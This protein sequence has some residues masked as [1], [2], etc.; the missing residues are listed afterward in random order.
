MKFWNDLR[1]RTKIFVLVA[2]G[3]LGLVVTGTLGLYNMDIMKNRLEGAEKDMQEVATLAELKNNFLQ[4]RLDLVYMLSL[5]DSARIAD[6]KQDF[7]QRAAT[8]KEQLAKFR[9]G[10]LSDKEKTLT[11][12]FDDGFSAYL[13][14][15]SKLGEMAKNAAA[16]GDAQARAAATDFA[17]STVAPLYD[18][19]AQAVTTIATDNV[20]DGETTFARSM[21]RFRRAST[22]MTVI[23]VGICLFAVAAGLAIA[24]SISRPLNRVLEVL[25]RVAAGDLTARADAASRDEMGLLAEELNTTAG[26]INEIVSRV[27]HNAEQVTAAATQLHATATQM[28]TGA[29]EVAQQA[30][31][32]AT[33]SEEMAAT[34][35]DIA[36]NCALAAENS[37][38]ANDRAETGSSVVQETLTVMNKIA[39]RVR[40]S[41]QTVESLGQRS[42]QIG[43]IIGTI[44]DIA[45]QTNLLALN[46]AIEAARAGEQ[47]RG[48]AVVADEVRALAERTTKATKEIAQMIKAIQGETKGAVVSMEE[49][50]KDVEK[51]TG[52]AAKSGD[53][54]EAILDQIGSVT[55]Q[56]SQIATAAEQQTATTAEINNNIQQITDVVQHTARGAEESAQAAEQLAKLA[57]EL[58]SLVSQFR[59]AS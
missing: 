17:V 36:R 58:Q 1:V 13:R 12:D 25:S 52:D 29:E 45:D 19:P 10:D 8:V 18:K 32:V 38:H 2:G 56:V 35:G 48:F 31:T 50:V 3:C 22:F 55:M 6:K 21:A 47:G 44:E 24:G 51:G 30:A 11:K 20:K 5:T 53:A 34:S 7:E 43:E 27:A 42:D 41:A 23:V 49:G 40:S 33:A 15:G 26:K 54:L 39:D 14:E 16:S 28:S 37:Q 4:M 46:A 57:E 9:S 59:L